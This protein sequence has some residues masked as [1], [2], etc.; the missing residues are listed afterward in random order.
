MTGIILLS[1]TTQESISPSNRKKKMYFANA[2]EKIF[3]L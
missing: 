2:Q 3:I 1:D